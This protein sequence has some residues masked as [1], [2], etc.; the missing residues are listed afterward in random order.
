MANLKTNREIETTNSNVVYNKI[1]REGWARRSNRAKYHRRDSRNNESYYFEKRTR[2]RHSIEPGEGRRKSA[3]YVYMVNG[4]EYP[5]YIEYYID[6]GK[7]KMPS[8]KLV[9]KNKKQW[10]NKTLIKN[11]SERINSDDYYWF[12]W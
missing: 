12:T 1:N 3:I 10:M 5:C 4:E 6:E 9:S 11:Y 8:W 2:W 7:L